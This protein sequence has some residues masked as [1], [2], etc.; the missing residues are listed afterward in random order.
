[1]VQLIIRQITPQL[2]RRNIRTTSINKGSEYPTRSPYDLG[3]PLE[4]IVTNNVKQEHNE[5][6][7]HHHFNTYHI[8]QE[9]ERQGF[10]KQQAVVIMKGMKFKLRERY[11]QLHEIIFTNILSSL[12]QLHEQLL[13]KSNLE[14]VKKK[15]KKKKKDFFFVNR[16]ILKQL[17][18]NLFVSSSSIRT[19]N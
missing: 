7:L 12:G 19:K 5:T 4:E 1:M 10:S 6:P 9:L 8:V 18:G 15:K 17:I 13:M 16:N 3:N 11:E 14:N 2:L